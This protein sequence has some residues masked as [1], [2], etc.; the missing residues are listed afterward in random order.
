M[1]VFWIHLCLDN[2]SA[3]CT[4]VLCYVL[5]QTHSEFWYI[6][7]FIFSWLLRH[8]ETLSRHIQA[9]SVTCVTLAY[10]Q[11]CHIL[12]PGMLRAGSLFKTL[13]NVDQTYLEPY[14]RILFS[15]IQAYS[16]P[17]TTLAYTETW[18]TWNLGIFRNLSYLQKFANIQSPDIFKTRYIFRTLPKV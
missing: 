3:I 18:Y 7:H 1:T 15:H 17:C 14:H 12:T 6:Q 16:E 8:I 11:P 9:Y 13:W 5:H 2:C 10:S 4:V